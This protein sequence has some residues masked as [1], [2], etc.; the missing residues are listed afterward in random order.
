MFDPTDYKWPTPKRLVLS[1]LSSPELKEIGARECVKWGRLF[2]IDP[3][4][5]RVALGRLVKAGFLRSVVRGRYAIGDRG[6]VLSET[7][8]RWVSAEERVGAWDGCWLMV[9][10]AHLGRRDQSALKLRDR[11]LQLV[12]FAELRSG[13]WCRPANYRESSAETRARLRELGLAE[14]AIILRADSLLLEPRELAALWP[15]NALEDAYAALTQAMTDSMARGDADDTDAGKEALARETFLLGEAV[16]RQINGDPLLPDA[17]VDVAARRKMHETMVAYEA[18]GRD[19]W[20]RFQ[21]PE[22]Q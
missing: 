14:E 2:D 8:R 19:A 17:M 3:T 18:F 7:A 10:T 21:T 1:L 16:I 13:L 5:M 15:R 4:A 12:G 11:A 22:A 9:H 20:A 6:R